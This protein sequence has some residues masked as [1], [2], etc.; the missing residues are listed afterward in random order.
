MSNIKTIV[1]GCGI[2]TEDYYG[3]PGDELSC[4]ECYIKSQTDYIQG[5]IDSKLKRIS[6]LQDEIVV[7]KDNIKA[8]P[9]KLE[10]EYQERLK[11]AIECD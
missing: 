7:L 6:R 10:T 9:A 11:H 2:E 8:L 4:R 1:C 5:D 3:Y